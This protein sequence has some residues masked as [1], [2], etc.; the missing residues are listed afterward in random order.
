MEPISLNQIIAC[1]R[2]RKK[3]LRQ[4]AVESEVPMGTI[5]KLLNT[6]KPVRNPRMD[7]FQKL[8]RYFEREAA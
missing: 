4:I 1:L 8:A 2:D 6:T 7:T 3:P 5:R